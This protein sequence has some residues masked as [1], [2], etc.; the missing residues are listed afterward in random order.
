MKLFDSILLKLRKYWAR[1]K[2]WVITS[3]GE[4]G[5]SHDTQDGISHDTQY[6]IKDESIIIEYFE[7]LMEELEK[8]GFYLIR[9]GDIE[10]LQTGSRDDFEIQMIVS[11]STSIFPEKM[12]R[13]IPKV[14]F[15]PQKYYQ[16]PS[17]EDCMEIMK[18][19]SEYK[20][21]FVEKNKGNHVFLKDEFIV[22]INDFFYNMAI[23][24]STGMQLDEYIKAHN[25]EKDCIPLVYNKM[26]R[27][28]S[29][30]KHV[31]MHKTG[32]IPTF[33]NP[34]SMYKS[35]YLKPNR[36]AYTAGIDDFGGLKHVY[37]RD[38]DPQ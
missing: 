30:S 27:M 21:I 33:I 28:G 37:I 14:L 10:L 18:I 24:G 31:K 5:I 34:F 17:P 36:F 29:L 4:D 20:N 3:F 23:A 32:L 19:K 1:I 8:R 16:I 2:Q 25:D 38:I 15:F 6:G 13:I 12:V 11:V 9:M 7:W 35:E 22:N 26:I